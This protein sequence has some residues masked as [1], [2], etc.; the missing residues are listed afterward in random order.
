MQPRWCQQHKLLLLCTVCPFPRLSYYW[1]GGAN[2]NHL[3]L[4]VLLFPLAKADKVTSFCSLCHYLGDIPNSNQLVYALA[5][6]NG[7]GNRNLLMLSIHVLFQVLPD[8]Q[9]F[10]IR[11]IGVGTSQTLPQF[12]LFITR[13]ISRDLQPRHKLSYGL[14]FNT[15]SADSGKN[16]TWT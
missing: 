12:L 15:S 8:H 9:P 1:H 4:R 2:N 11:K 10:L 14:W 5:H 7:N 6:G 13:A 16:S 3:H